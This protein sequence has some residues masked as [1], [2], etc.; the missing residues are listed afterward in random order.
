LQRAL[1][2]VEAA[3]DVAVEEERLGK[4]QLIVLRAIASLQRAR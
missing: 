3:G 4:R 1:V 2:D